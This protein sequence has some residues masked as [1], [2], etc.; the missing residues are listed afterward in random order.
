MYTTTKVFKTTFEKF[1]E[2]KAI[3]DRQGIK[4]FVNITPRN[5]DYKDT[6]AFGYFGPRWIVAETIISM[7][8]DADILVFDE[9]KMG[10]HDYP[11]KMAYNSIH[12]SYL[13]AIQYTARLDSLL[14]TFK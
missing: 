14:E 11:D 9:N 6:G 3:A 7:F 1:K 13:G 10:N 8:E 12:L 2:L 5:P 4:F